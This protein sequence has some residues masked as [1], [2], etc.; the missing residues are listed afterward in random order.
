MLMFVGLLFDFVFHSI[1]ST[2]DLEDVCVVQETVEDG[3]CCWNIADEFPPFFNGPVGGHH[4]GSGFVSSHDNFK[5]V[6][7]GFGR[8]L[9][10][11]HIINDEQ[12]A[13]EVFGHDAFVFFKEIVMQKLVNNIK[14]RAVKNGFSCS[15][16]C[17]SDGLNQMAFSYSG[18]ANEEDIVFL[19]KEPSCSQLVDVFTVDRWVKAKIKALQRALISETGRTGPS[20]D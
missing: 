15:D 5:E 18:R 3:R 8:Q 16:K 14:D 20:L 1:T 17:L 2:F 6:F 12:I 13:L 11:S 7:T 10:D 4:C 19:I 9:F